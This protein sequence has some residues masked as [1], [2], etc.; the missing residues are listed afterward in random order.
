MALLDPSFLQ[1]R[2]VG[3]TEDDQSIRSSYKLLGIVSF[4]HLG[5]TLGIYAYNLRHRQKTRKE[6]KLHRNLSYQMYKVWIFFLF[7]GKEN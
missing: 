7:T 3:F 5:L 1:L 2:S 4:L 6:W